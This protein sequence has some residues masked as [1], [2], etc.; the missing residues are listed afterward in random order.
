[1]KGL[2]GTI[3]KLGVEV[4]GDGP[5]QTFHPL[6]LQRQQPPV[7]ELLPLS[8]CEAT[9][10]SPCWRLHPRALQRRLV[11]ADGG[12]ATVL[13]IGNGRVKEVLGGGEEGVVVVIVDLLATAVALEEA[14][15]G[16][17]L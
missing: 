12:R 7:D 9:E 1:M 14:A 6:F 2:K 15:G 16:S 13:M 8:S 3:A 17:P 11:V 4:I 10:S 5:Q